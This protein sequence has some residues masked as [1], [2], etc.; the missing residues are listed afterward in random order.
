MTHVLFH[1]IPA[2]SDKWE[3]DILVV[4]LSQI[5]REQMHLKSKAQER[6]LT[7]W[8]TIRAIEI[9]QEITEILSKIEVNDRYLQKAS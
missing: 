3:Q 1:T 7:E 5:S 2:N 8:E 4:E 9:H 6:P